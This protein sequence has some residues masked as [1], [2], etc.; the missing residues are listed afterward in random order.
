MIVSNE[1]GF[2]REGEYGIRI[3]NLV[4]VLPAKE[5]A[6][7]SVAVHEFETL[8]LAPIDRRLVD[9]SLL[10]REEIDWLDLYHERVRT[11]LSPHLSEEDRSWLVKA[12]LPISR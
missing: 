7:G 8:T 10:T 9:V 6:G 12:T 1:P 3:E 4:L 11:A 2:Y 5:I